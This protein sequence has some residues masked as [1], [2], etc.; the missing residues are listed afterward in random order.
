MDRQMGIAAD[1]LPPVDRRNDSMGCLLLT[2]GMTLWLPPVDRWN[3]SMG[4]LLLTD[5]M[6]LWVASC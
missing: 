1:G 4:C 3:D 5:G 6:T 2:D